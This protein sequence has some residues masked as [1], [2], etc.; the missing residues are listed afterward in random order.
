MVLLSCCAN[1]A[2]QS[3]DTSRI[4]EDFV[5]ACV[6]KWTHRADADR[7]SLGAFDLTVHADGH[8]EAHFDHKT[9][10]GVWR[11]FGTLDAGI[12]MT[13]DKTGEQLEIIECPSDQPAVTL[14]GDAN[15]YRVHRTV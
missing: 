7:T 13:D 3:V 10:S 1:T 15:E 9:L 12:R 2:P 6:G 14:S 4:A 8:F 11:S 5:R